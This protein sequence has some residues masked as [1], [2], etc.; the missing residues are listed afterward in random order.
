MVIRKKLSKASPSGNV[1]IVSRID[2]GKTDAL[3]TLQMLCKNY[4]HRM[5]MHDETKKK[6]SQN[7]LQSNFRMFLTRLTVKNR[8]VRKEMLQTRSL[9]QEEVLKIFHS[10]QQRE[11]AATKIQTGYRGMVARKHLYQAS[12]NAFPLNKSMAIGNL[13][14]NL[15]PLKMKHESK[16]ES[17]HILQSNF[18][19]F[20]TR[21]IL[22]TAFLGKECCMQSLLLR[23]QF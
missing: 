15:K 23:K 1:K 4:V 14:P 20:L 21:F 5:R 9:A 7:I 2:I 17:Q 19:M 18:R 12:T 13:H 16:T 11:V 22:K 3:K 8:F 10:M 6:E